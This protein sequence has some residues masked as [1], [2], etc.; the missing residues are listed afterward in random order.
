MGQRLSPL[1]THRTDGDAGP[2]V[3]GWTESPEGP[4][5]APDLIDDRGSA[6]GRRHRTESDHEADAE[7]EAGSRPDSARHRE[8]TD[9]GQFLSRAPRWLF[10]AV[11][12]YAPW[13]YGCTRPWTIDLLNIALFAVT[14]LWLAGCL[15]TRE[16]PRVHPVLLTAAIL[17]LLQGWWMTGN[18]GFSYDTALQPH[19][20]EPWARAWP[21]AVD[22]AAALPAMTGLSAML[23]AACFACDLARRRRWRQRLWAVIAVAGISIVVL[24]LAQKLTGAPGIFWQDEGHARTFFGPYRYHANAGSFINLVWPLAAALLLHS[25]RRDAPLPIRLFWGAGLL[26]CIGGAVANTSRASGIITVAFL[27]SWLAILAV[28]LFRRRSDGPDPAAILGLGLAVVAAILGVLATGALDTTLHRWSQ[29]D[30]ELTTDNSRLLVA[31]TCVEMLP[32]SGWLGF[33][34]GTFKTAFPFFNQDTSAATRGIW[35]QAHQDYLQTLI[36]WGWI[37]AALWAL[38]PGGALAIGAWNALRQRRTWAGRDRHLHVAATAAIAAVL[39]HA[40]VDFPLQIASIQLYVVVLAG[41]LWSTPLW[42]RHE[43]PSPAD[44]SPA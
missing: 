4:P 15:V 42:V 37:G 10:L 41:L 18:A 35:L 34:P 19:A 2:A 22:H 11:L 33:G 36:E 44:D 1:P 39:I 38:I 27:G 29:L 31:R 26:L 32:R 23:G 5:Q 16:R 21:G 13:A 25:I 7:A 9:A 40:L 43:E 28:R 14:G 12:V 20:R 6:R 17:L 30:R 8:R 3:A 24:G